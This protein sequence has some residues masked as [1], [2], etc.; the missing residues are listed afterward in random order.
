MGEYERVYRRSIDD[1]D[2]FWAEAARDI[3]WTRQPD[4]VLDDSRPPFYRWFAGGELNTCANA[5]D[6][7]VA[8]GR[9]DQVALIYDSPVTGGV[10]RFALRFGL[11]R[12]HV[13]RGLETDGAAR[14][15]GAR[16]SVAR[17]ASG[18]SACTLP[19]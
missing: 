6:R 16:A 19:R 12:E 17:P 2:G 5:L 14:Q 11:D 4:R 10:E 9:G 7:H 15:R 13:D 18:V 3:D 1:P 8:A